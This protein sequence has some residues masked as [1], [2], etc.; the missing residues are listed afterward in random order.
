MKHTQHLGFWLGAI[1]IAFLVAPIFR[2]QADLVSYVYDEL[3]QIRFALGD[4]VADKVTEF[5]NTVF[6]ETPLGLIAQSAATYAPRETDRRLSNEVAGPLGAM[7]TG[8]LGGYLEGLMLQSYVL[9]M[10]LAIVVVWMVI[11]APM[12]IAAVF[13]GYM[14]RKVKRAEFG[15]IRPATFSIAAALIIP[16]MCLPLV[17]M[18]LPLPMNPLVAPLWAL[19]V[20]FPLSMLVANMQPIVGR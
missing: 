19:V 6:D 4:T 3:S 15:M 18:V 20:V 16:A 12:L 10:R 9:A 7:A 5:A 2:G 1:F 13:D 17:Y 11:L 8:W 14:M